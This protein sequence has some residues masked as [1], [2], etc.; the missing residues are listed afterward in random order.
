MAELWRYFNN[1]HW[2]HFQKHVVAVELPEHLDFYELIRA[3]GLFE[4]D[5][6]QALAALSTSV[7]KGK[8]SNYKEWL[9][10]KIPALDGHTP[11]ELSSHPHSM[12][13]LREYIIRL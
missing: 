2:V 5:I 4:D 1:S 10:K 3:D 6:H 9:H 7:F 12:N 13:W 11:A 8:T